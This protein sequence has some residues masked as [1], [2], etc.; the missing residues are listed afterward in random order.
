MKCE[1]INILDAIDNNWNAITTC[2]HK[3]RVQ[4]FSKVL[5]IIL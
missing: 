2:I 5:V 4:S 3:Q 1:D